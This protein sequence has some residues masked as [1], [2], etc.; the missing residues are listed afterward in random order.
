[1]SKQCDDAEI[2][3]FY[4]RS[5]TEYNDMYI[6]ILLQAVEVFRSIVL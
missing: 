3:V 4:F 5:S 2:K 6:C 1:M